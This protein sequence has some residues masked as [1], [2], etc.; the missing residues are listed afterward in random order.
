MCIPVI[1]TVERHQVSFARDVDD[2]EADLFVVRLQIDH[3]LAVLSG[4]RRLHILR[5]LSLGV[6]IDE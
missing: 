5:K 1:H 2:L 4:L 3:S 6:H